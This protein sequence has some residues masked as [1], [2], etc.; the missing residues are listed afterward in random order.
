MSPPAA[1]VPG[2]NGTVAFAGSTIAT[3]GQTSTSTLASTSASTLGTRATGV[4]SNDGLGSGEL[5]AMGFVVEA[6]DGLTEADAADL[7]AILRK[8]R[9]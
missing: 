3:S 6:G 4:R 7:S 9:T 8:V 5:M 1:V 2:K